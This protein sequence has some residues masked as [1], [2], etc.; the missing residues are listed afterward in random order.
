MSTFLNKLSAFCCFHRSTGVWYLRIISDLNPAC[1]SHFHTHYRQQGSCFLFK[2]SGG[3]RSKAKKEKQNGKGR[4]GEGMNETPATEHIHFSQSP[5]N[6]CTQLQAFLFLYVLSPCPIFS[7][8]RLER[9]RR[10]WKETTTSRVASD[11][12]LDLWPLDHFELGFF[13][14]RKWP[15]ECAALSFS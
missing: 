5:L 12:V 8:A 14:S 4:G 2:S 1:S 13:A 15:C 9:K 10:R 3:L 7:P 11:F 6:L